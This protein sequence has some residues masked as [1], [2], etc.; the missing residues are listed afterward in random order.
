MLTN[1]S[2]FYFSV[3]LE[4]V[5]CL[6]SI[7][8]PDRLPQG[9][10]GA[11]FSKL[12]YSWSKHVRNETWLKSHPIA[13]VLL[14]R[15]FFSRLGFASLCFQITAITTGLC[16]INRFT[17]MS[18]TELVYSLFADCQEGYSSQR[19]GLCVIDP[20]TFQEI[21]PIIQAVSVAM[22]TKAFLTIVTFGIK[23]PAGI[24]IPSLGVG[25]CAGR[26][27]GLVIQWLQ[28]QKLGAKLFP[29]C[30]KDRDC[31]CFLFALAEETFLNVLQV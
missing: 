31:E 23:V 10:Y 30:T 6:H 29:I 5:V 9:I 28:Y 20:R 18:G 3:C 15:S 4:F 12:N 24:F 16:F 21:W 25:A 17:R 14:V 2:L 8:L 11:Y 13:E 27:M 1:S 26:I 19:A 7:L 22:V